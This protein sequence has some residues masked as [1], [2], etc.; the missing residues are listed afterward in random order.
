MKGLQMVF[1]YTHR[2]SALLSHGQMSFILQQM[3]TNAETH[4]QTSCR[5]TKTLEYKALNV[6]SPSNPCPSISENP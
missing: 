6:I 4:S 5:E 1:G 3:G 2:L